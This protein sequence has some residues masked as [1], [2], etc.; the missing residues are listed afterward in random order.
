[1][2]WIAHVKS[3]GRLV[4]R[5]ALINPQV[6]SHFVFLKGCVRRRTEQFSDNILQVVNKEAIQ[7]SI[8]NTTVEP[9]I[10]PDKT[11]TRGS[12]WSSD[13]KHGF[14]QFHKVCCNIKCVVICGPLCLRP[15]G[16]KT[17]TLLE[18]SQKHALQGESYN[19]KI[20]TMFDLTTSTL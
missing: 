8:Y 14:K 1:M 2:F 19:T 4:S 13:A 12:S 6:S 5:P 15:R 18:L 17:V 10:W 3:I 20:L 16:T 9:G 7:I 11:V